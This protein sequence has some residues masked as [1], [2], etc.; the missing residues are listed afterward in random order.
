M[1]LIVKFIIS[2]VSTLTIVAGASLVWP[3]LTSS[4]RPEP[5]TQVRNMVLTTDIG[6]SIAQTLGVQDEATVTPVDVGSVAGAAISSAA[7]DVQQK[8]S[9]AVTREVIIQIV[10][11]IETLAPGEQ[12]AIKEQICQ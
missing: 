4:P 10:K 12:Q 6:N 9:S 7:A 2:L 11:K 3:K 1:P 8:A 5:L